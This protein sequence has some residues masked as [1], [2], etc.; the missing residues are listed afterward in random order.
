[1]ADLDG[2][3]KPEAISVNYNAGTISIF[4]NTGSGTISTGLFAA[5]VDFSVGTVPRNVAIADFDG[6]GKPDIVAANNLGIGVSSTVTVLRNTTTTGVI[7]SSSFAAG[8]TYSTGEQSQFVVADDIDVD[9]KIDL[10]VTNSGAGGQNGTVSVLRNTSTPGVLNAAS[11]QTAV[12]FFAGSFPKNVTT[13]DLN[14]DGRPEILAANQYEIFVFQ[15]TTGTGIVNT[16]S[17]LPATTLPIPNT[18]PTNPTVHRLTTGDIDGDGK[19]DIIVSYM[20][21]S[22]LSVWRNLYSGGMITYGSFSERETISTNVMGHGIDLSDIDG[23]GKVDVVFGNGKTSAANDS[24]IVIRRNLST[25]GTN[26]F[27][28]FSNAANSGWFEM[29]ANSPDLFDVTVCDM[30]ND[31]IP[32]VVV[33]TNNKLN[34]F[35]NMPIQNRKPRFTAGASATVTYCQLTGAAAINSFL[36]V[37]D[38][39]AGQTLTWTLLRAPAHGSVVTG[40]TAL[41]TTTNVTPAGNTYTANDGF[42]GNDTFSIVVNDGAYLGLDTLLVYVTVGSALSSISG[43]LTLCGGGTTTLTNP[44][45][46]GTWSSSATTIATVGSA[47]G[48]V[49]GKSG[50]TAIISYA[51]TPTCRA[52]AVLT[53]NPPVAITGSASVLLGTTK[54]LTNASP[55][56]IWSSSNAA[57][58]SIGS[59]TGIVAGIA[60]GT[61]TISYTIGSCYVTAP[62]QS[63]NYC[64]PSVGDGGE[65]STTGSYIYDFSVT[66][67]SGTSIAHLN[68]GYGGSGTGYRNATTAVPPVSF[69]AGS[70]YTVTLRVGTVNPLGAQVWIDF[71][72][73]GVFTASETIGGINSLKGTGTFTV[74]IP[75]D[76]PAGTFRM[77]IRVG[78]PATYP[79]INSCTSLFTGETHDYTAIILSGCTPPTIS[80]SGNVTAGAAAGLCTTNVSYSAASATGSS[81]VVTYSQASGT[82]FPVGVTTVTSTATNTCGTATCNFT[83]AVTAAPDTIVGAD[84]LCPGSTTTFSTTIAGGT[85][86]SSNAS[87][88][89][90]SAG[91]MFTAI[92]AGTTIATYT[93]TTACATVTATKTIVVKAAPGMTGANVG[94]C[95][96]SSTTLTASGASTYSWAPAA[97]LSS[98]TGANVTASPTTLTNYTVTGTTNGC[99]ASAIYTVSVNPVPAITL[100]THPTVS[101]SATGAD[102]PIT[103][104]TGSP[105]LY[106]ISFS[107]PALTFGFSNVSG[108]TISG[109]SITIPMPATSV[110]GVYT[111]TLTVATANCTSGAYTFSVTISETIVPL[112]A[113]QSQ[114]NVSCFG[115]CNGTASVAV[116]GGT[117]P[118]NYSWLPSGGSAATA[119]GL[120]AGTY[121]CT[122]TDANMNTITRSF[123]ITQPAALVLT[124]VANSGAACAGDTVQL[125]CT[126]TGGT[127]P[128]NFEWSGPNGFSSTV[129]HPWV[130][131]DTTA[132]GA[133]TVNVTD[134]NECA[135][136][137]TNTT[138]VT[139]LPQ[140]F[141]NPVTGTTTVCAGNNTTLAAGG[142]SAGTWSSSNT[143]VA[144]ITATGIVTGIIAGTSI[145]SYIVTNAC[146]TAG[147]ATT[148]SVLPAPSAATV[149]GS[150]NICTGSAT[151]LTASLPDGSWTSSNITVASVNTTGSVTGIAAGTA[152]ISYTLTNSCGSATA[153]RV[154]TV[155][156]G[157]V[158]ATVSGASLL[159]AGSQATYTISTTG[160]VWS[161]SNAAA[162][163]ISPAGVL[164]GI[165]GGVTT[166]SYTVSNA[167][168]TAAATQTVTV[169]PLP[170]QPDSITGPS[171]LCAGGTINMSGPSG[172]VWSSSNA[173][174]ATI[175]SSGM[176]TGVAAGVATISYTV[177]NACGNRYAQK[178]ITVNAAPA[179][180]SGVLTVCPGAI[181]TL[182]NS[183]GGGTWSSTDATVSVTASNGK[184]TGIT[185]GTA[186]INYNLPAGC[187]TSVIVTVTPMPGPVTGTLQVCPGATTTL[188]AGA[189]GGTWS[190]SSVSKATVDAGTGVVTG[191][192]TGIAV[193]TYTQ[194]AGCFAT[195]SLTV[196]AA[197]AAIGGAPATCPGSSTQLSCTTAGGIWTSSNTSIATV[198]A[199]TGL[200]TS[201]AGVGTT[202]I[203]YTIT[204]QCP[205]SVVVAV[206]AASPN[207]GTPIVCLG[208]P[209]SV[210][211]ITNATPG[212]TWSSS[213]PSI[214]P[215]NQ[216][217]GLVKGLSLGT[218]TITYQLGSGCMSTSTLTVNP[219]VA[220]IIGDI[221][222]CPG[223]STTLSNTTPG[224]TWSSTNTSV[225]VAGTGGS[226]AA[227]F[228][229]TSTISYIV[230]AGCYKSTTLTVYG[231][232]ADITGNDVMCQGSSA[233]LTCSPAGGTWTS[234]NTNASVVI[235]TG[236]ITGVATGTSV[237]SYKNSS[238]GCYTIK[239]ITINPSVATITGTANIC[240]GATLSL[241]NAD[242]GGTWSTGNPG[243]ATIDAT[244]GLLTGVGAGTAVITYTTAPACYRTMIQTIKTV[245]TPIGGASSVCLSSAATVT[246]TPA[247]GTWS[248]SNNSLATITA[249]GNIT[250]VSPGVVTVAYTGTNGCVAT[251]DISVNVNP[252]S[253]TGTPAICQGSTSALGSSPLGGMWSS[254]NNAKAVVDSLTGLVTAISQGTAN[255][256]YMLPTGC[257]R[258]IT[259][260]VNPLP[261]AI[262]GPATLVQGTAANFTSTPAGGTWSSSNLATATVIS[263]TGR[264]TGIAAGTTTLSYQTTLGCVVTRVISIVAARGVSE[265]AIPE[266]RTSFRIYPNPTAGVINIETSETGVLLIG[267]MDGKIVAQFPVTATATAITL[268][269]NLSP[270]VYVCYLSGANGTVIVGK[271]V[272]QP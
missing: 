185:P 113:S 252:G 55:G 65:S 202:T 85:W 4:R 131:A 192:N 205:R 93:A 267:S 11:F 173:T 42:S 159:C 104:S 17:F 217:T 220:P 87:A 189:T 76:A 90:V 234:N 190:S 142:S 199:A 138:T 232:M 241:S 229:G 124:A 259:A 103:A 40:S 71:G 20:A 193:I 123:T 44:T 128:M 263:A 221:N 271:L 63:G 30:D 143:S 122:T 191:I 77:R 72:E 23:D 209:F 52:M 18:P 155:N 208:Q 127:A 10:I 215:I 94:V 108:A 95:N 245:P 137:G 45:P 130:I 135:A 31:T 14:G 187:S 79:N 141:A 35:K 82:A 34:I 24:L 21:R 160:G 106:S 101:I 5:K 265:E 102:L 118:Y 84:S 216:I 262:T 261:A 47:T 67:A 223:S 174:K 117:P 233:T 116:S 6:D 258:R 33:I 148:V 58:A 237:V 266:D 37:H 158:P 238:T 62:M 145:I 81:P 179:T 225:A 200:V 244:S 91:G 92:A 227:L 15:N 9:G 270:G 175:N 60:S 151:T 206:A 163:T 111:G 73:D 269:T 165:N 196:N 264:A 110:A 13:A 188:A 180:I 224:G 183:P 182:T 132:H 184:V 176:V 49:A 51:T 248:S 198:N 153:T 57:I 69:A 272:Y 181:T 25:P 254:S 168:G 139:L 53:V 8:V 228:E 114:Q 3:N 27:A 26:N 136:T 250:G 38:T 112:A 125:S 230:N 59:T 36:Q 22:S 16:S 236:Q 154:V 43:T 80:C 239:V 214:A 255:I 32:D 28:P 178:S 149:S 222:I 78:N 126:A 204:G 61:V 170:G 210:A 147:T 212:G 251:K 74:N 197:P 107:A 109:P 167:C 99:S 75:A 177:S 253:I 140:P 146:G 152:V 96:G 246:S 144:T 257:F 97:G 243:V 2:D 231:A 56:G 134:G 164:A 119:S 88:G 100:G 203:S 260:V 186:T 213:D 195:A 171:A 166:V 41:A 115:V 86:S 70:S 39:D 48:V 172:G 240:P 105:T 121:T 68:T 129:Q 207:A 194:S 211:A 268:P 12:N 156:A 120:C 162:A 235:T 19:K 169:S 226:F 50:G 256:T 201:V 150:A 133:Y 89:T 157:S 247:G 249:A 64:T 7:N 218:V 46:G 242:V 83:V 54:T 1:M 161:S 98:T 219:A 66:G 29:R